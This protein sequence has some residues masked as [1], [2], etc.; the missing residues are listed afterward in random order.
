MSTFRLLLWLPTSD[1]VFL[2]HYQ[3]LAAADRVRFC[4]TKTLGHGSGKII[5]MAK[6]LRKLQ[7]DYQIVWTIGCYYIL[8]A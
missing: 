8:F 4:S 3:L 7:F 6:Y 5:V 2:V 1:V